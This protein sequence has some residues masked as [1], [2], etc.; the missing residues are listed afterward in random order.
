MCGKKVFKKKCNNSV[1]HLKG[2]LKCELQKVNFMFPTNVSRIYDKFIDTVFTQLIVKSF[3]PFILWILEIK[4]I[5]FV[6]FCLPYNYSLHVTIFC[7]K[8]KKF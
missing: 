5:N 3:V 4:L 6:R 2:S 7:W 8:L 1:N